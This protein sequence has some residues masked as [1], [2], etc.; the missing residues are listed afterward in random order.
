MTFESTF[1]V[2]A[3]NVFSKFI[4]GCLLHKE[5]IGM[6]IKAMKKGY[7]GWHKP[8]RGKGSLCDITKGHFLDLCV[9]ALFKLFLFLWN[10]LT[11]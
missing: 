8:G 5:S 2:N 7:G 6:V 1:A 4:P 9:L 11:S 3:H 10:S